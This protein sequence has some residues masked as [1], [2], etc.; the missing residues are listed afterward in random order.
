MAIE[1]VTYADLKALLG[2]TKAAMSDYP[3][4]EVL[5]DS[6]L[7]AIEEY[8]GRELEKSDRTETIFIGDTPSRMISLLGLPIASITS[9]TITQAQIETSY[10]STDYD[11]VD[12][13]IKMVSKFKNA[14]IVVVYNGGYADADVPTKINRAALL[15]ISY[16]WQ[17]KDQ[18]GAQSV[19]TEGGFVQRPELGLLKEVKRMLDGQKHPLRLL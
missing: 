15:Q 7:Y 2:L 17:S 1:L 13:G 10:I 16:E 11:V 9:V 8:L 4:L 14:K 6:V 19:S 5:N 3:A 12:Y 18:I